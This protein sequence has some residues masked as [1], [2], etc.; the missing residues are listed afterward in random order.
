MVR[1][2][3]ACHPPGRQAAA[4]QACANKVARD[5]I[6]LLL[7]TSEIVLEV[8]IGRAS[9]CGNLDRPPHIG[10]DCRLYGEWGG[11]RPLRGSPWGAAFT[12]LA[13]M[14][15]SP[16]AQTTIAR[17]CFVADLDDD[18]IRLCH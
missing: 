3:K 11:D 18:D 17:S 10:A 2:D 4:A 15:A 14:V 13:A 9:A 7:N 16:R 8:I 6:D 5:G 12:L 1:C